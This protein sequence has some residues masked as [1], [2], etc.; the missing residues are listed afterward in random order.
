MDGE[1][2]AAFLAEPRWAAMCVKDGDGQLRPTP[3]WLEPRPADELGVELLEAPSIAADDMA[4]CLVCDEFSSYLGIRGVILRGVLR[5]DA[6][7]VDQR[8]RTFTVS[9][10]YG[11]SFENSTVSL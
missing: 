5:A 6:S 8:R 9:K 3:V 4:G 2:L 7:A 11:F 10:A 1:Q